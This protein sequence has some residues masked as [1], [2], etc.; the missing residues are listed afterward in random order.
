M[1]LSLKNIICATDFSDPANDTI[2]YGVSLAKE[3]N[4]KLYVCHVIDLSSATLYGDATFAFETQ[5]I[6]MEEYAQERL[7]RLMD[8]YD[9]EWEPLVSTGNAADEV[10]RLAE[11]MS[12]DLT[13]TAT[14]GHSGLKRLILGSVTEHLMRT[15]PCPLLAVHRYEKFPDVPATRDIG[16]KRVLVGCDFSPNSDLAFQYGLSLAQEY[17]AELHLIH[18]LEPPIYK[19]IPKAAE[20][21][22]EVVRKNLYE[23]LKQKLEAMVPQDALNWCKPK[24]MLLAGHPDDELIKYADIQGIDLIV[25]GVAGHGLVESFFVGSTTERVMRKASCAVLSVRP[26]Q[27]KKHST[28]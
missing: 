3:F 27:E 13:I 21:A 6:H 5:L 22:R 10:A 14:H 18:V 2:N 4:A 8:S 24:T 1:R 17:E 16:F 19:D 20:A 28:E 11:E 9:I 12:A 25:M 15:L 7:R 23:Q 26:I